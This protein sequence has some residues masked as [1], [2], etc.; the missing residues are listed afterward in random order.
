MS[1]FS[2][3]LP[4]TNSIELSPFNSAILGLTIIVPVAT[5]SRKSDLTV[6]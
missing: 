4:S 6:G 2:I 5:R 3:T 1:I